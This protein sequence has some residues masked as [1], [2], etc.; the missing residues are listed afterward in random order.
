[1][2]GAEAYVS[3]TEYVIIR[4]PSVLVPHLVLHMP[5]ATGYFVVDGIIGILIELSH[6]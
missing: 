5:L 3:L 2:V 1:M 4:N 6:S